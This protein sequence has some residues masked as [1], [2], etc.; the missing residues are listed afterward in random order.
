MDWFKR[1]EG[2]RTYLA[3]AG[4]ILASLATLIGTVD[5][6]R[7][8]FAVALCLALAQAFQRLATSNAATLIGTLTEEIDRLRRLLGGSH[9]PT[10]T[11][12]PEPPPPLD[13]GDAVR[14]H[15]SGM[16][17]FALSLCLGGSCL[18]QDSGDVSLVGPSEVSAAGLPCDLHLQGLDGKKAVAVAWRVFPGVANVRMMEARDG[19]RIGRLTTIA[20]T[21]TVVVAYHTEGE[22]VRIVTTLV[23]VAGAP[24]VP[25]PGP[26]PLPPGPSPTPAP[27]PQPPGPMPPA[28]VPGPN[29]DPTPTPKPPGPTPPGPAPAPEL[30]AGDFDRLPARVRDLANAV[31]SP[32]RT[33]EAVNIADAIEGISAQIAAGTLVG[34]QTIVNALGVALNANTTSAWDDCRSKMVDSLKSLYMGGKLKTPAA[35]ATMLREVVLGLRAVK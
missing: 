27:T 9:P 23:R 18:A 34:P 10:P 24:Y 2:Y 28:P 15:S 12:A 20:G 19:G 14:P 3:T 1:L 11:P 4:T 17:A 5:P 8:A 29:V 13:F 22:P 35:W 33:T 21:W 30:P 6:V 31:N 7:G 16:M 32:T 26:M 25:P